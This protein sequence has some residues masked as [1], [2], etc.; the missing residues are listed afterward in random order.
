MRLERIQ[1]ICLEFLR[2]TS[3]PLTPVQLLFEQCMN[4]P[5]ARE[6]LTQNA[7][8]EFLRN[9][10]DVMVVE[11]HE[12]TPWVGASDFNGVG[13]DMG[14]RAILKARIPSRKELANILHEQ[15]EEMRDH[16][17]DALKAAQRAGDEK[18]VRELEAALERADD[19]GER[20]SDFQ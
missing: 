6:A 20:M 15:V 3:N 16:L 18:A 1:E 19:I 12:D 10:Q 4:D 2:N 13:L 5:G 17:R 7:L 9:H 11:A 8:L 14:P